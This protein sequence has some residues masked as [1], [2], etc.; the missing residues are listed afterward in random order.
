MKILGR[1]LS[2]DQIFR[3]SCLAGTGQWRAP[4]R[5]QYPGA[6]LKATERNAIQQT[7]PNYIKRRGFDVMQATNK[8]SGFDLVIV[9]WGPSKKEQPAAADGDEWCSSS[10]S[11]S[12]VRMGCLFT[13]DMTDAAQE[14][15]PCLGDKGG[16][17]FLFL[18]TTIMSECSKRP[19]LY[20]Y[21][22][23]RE[24][25]ADVKTTSAQLL[26]CDGLG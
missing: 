10:S 4:C 3:G 14:P 1:L 8:S 21:H 12:R 9:Q 6:P 17:G 13:P 5:L 7:T 20:M 19:Y 11:S 25:L 18:N 2:A 23:A 26:V 15:G 24:K 22:S 16:Q